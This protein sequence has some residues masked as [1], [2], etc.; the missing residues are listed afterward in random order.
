[1]FWTVAILFLVFEAQFLFLGYF[2]WHSYGVPMS[3]YSACFDVQTVAQYQEHERFV[4]C[5]GAC[6]CGNVYGIIYV[7]F[8]IYLFRRSNV[9]S[10]SRIRGI[11]FVY[12]FPPMWKCL[13][14]HKRNFQ[15]LRNDTTLM[16]NVRKYRY[17]LRYV[18]TGTYPVTAHVYSQSFFVKL[19][20]FFP[21]VNILGIYE[22]ALRIRICILLRFGPKKAFG[23]RIKF[24]CST[25]A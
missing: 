3:E 15:N 9:D 2:C 6:Q 17:L 22:S 25:C 8:K 13:W 12:R 18:G 10:V 21:E 1:M 20:S 16:I 14:N 23:M 11:C 5:T 4:F 19:F 24:W 7:I